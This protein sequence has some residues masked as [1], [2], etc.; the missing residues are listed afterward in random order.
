MPSKQMIMAFV[1]GV[2]V[3]I[4]GLYAY[5]KLVAAGLLK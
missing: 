4:T 3:T 1:G 2:L 5:N